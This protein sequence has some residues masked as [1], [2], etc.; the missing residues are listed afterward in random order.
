[1]QVSAAMT[2]GVL[3][4]RGQTV[5]P[6]AARDLSADFE[7]DVPAKTEET[8]VATGAGDIAAR[9]LGGS[10]VLATRGGNITVDWLGGALRA[11]TR[12]GN[13]DGG[14]GGAAARPVTPGGGGGLG[15]A[16]G[17]GGGKTS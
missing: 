4:F 6:G 13:I 11:E 14:A 17:E 2:G 16:Q 9:G 12:G 1:M 7:I 8:E 10:A 3:L 15:S 5:S